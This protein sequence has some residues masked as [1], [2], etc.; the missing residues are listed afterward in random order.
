MADGSAARRSG[1]AGLL[2]PLFGIVFVLF[3]IWSSMNAYDKADSYEDAEADYQHRRAMLL[4]GRR[5]PGRQRRRPARTASPG[6]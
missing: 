4:A 6:D 1:F 2:F 3:G 5:D